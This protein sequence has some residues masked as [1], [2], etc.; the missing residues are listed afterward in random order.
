[1]SRQ[2][3]PPNYANTPQS[4]SP[5]PP[6][7]AQQQQQQ[8]LRQPHFDPTASSPSPQ[9][10]PAPSAALAG[11]LKGLSLSGVQE[12]VPSSN[13][14]LRNGGNASPRASPTPATAPGD[15][16]AASPLQ[17]QQQQQSDVSAFSEGGTTYF[18]NYGSEE[19]VRGRAKMS[20][21]DDERRANTQD[22]TRGNARRHH[23]VLRGF[24]CAL[25][26]PPCYL[27]C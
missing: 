3:P 7:L 25:F 12:F 4:L 11:G 22:A 10:G 9:N 23:V 16:R 27:P 21:D 17:Q 5:V 24:S 20:P 6:Q 19:V 14:R 15:P 2:Q 13:F 8:P 26:F 18:Y 1:M